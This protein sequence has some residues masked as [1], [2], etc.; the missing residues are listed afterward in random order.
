MCVLLISVCIY[1]NYP[2]YGR[3]QKRVSLTFR[4]SVF[5]NKDWPTN[6]K[7]G[8]VSVRELISQ[9]MSD[10]IT[11][12]D[13]DKVADV[14]LHQGFTN[15]LFA[16]LSN[17]KERM[18]HSPYHSKFD[19]IVSV[20]K[21][22][23]KHP[24]YSNYQL[25]ISG[26][27]LGGALAQLMTFVVGSSETCRDLF[28]SPILGISYASPSVGNKA[29]SDAMNKLQKDGIAYHIRITNEAD[30]V[31]VGFFWYEQ[32]GIN[33]HAKYGQE[34]KLGGSGNT[35][36]L[37]SEFR[38]NITQC[39]EAHSVASHSVRDSYLVTS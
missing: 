4:G 24:V 33:F 21:T 18:L 11:K 39:V 1:L 38:F 36:T 8:Q 14:K 37:F 31:P 35:Q 26:H 3:S 34:L 2:Y 5:G 17:E 32:S 12:S 23:Y 25:V 29:F 30:L 7:F 27:S 9:I 22:I 10:F 20:L 28:P 6:L 16:D 13:A 19:K 15:Y